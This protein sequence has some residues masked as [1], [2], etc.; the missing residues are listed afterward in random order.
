MREAGSEVL[1]EDGGKEDEEVRDVVGR[2]CEGFVE[3]GAVVLALEEDAEGME[4]GV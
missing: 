1:E 2:W 3:R 4:G